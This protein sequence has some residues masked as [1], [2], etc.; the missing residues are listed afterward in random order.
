MGCSRHSGRCETGYNAVALAIDGAVYDLIKAAE[1]TSDSTSPDDH[2]D[3]R[4]TA[5]TVELN[6]SISGNLETQRDIDYFRFELNSAGKI[7]AVTTGDTDT[8]GTLQNDS[9]NVVVTNDDG[10]SSR[11]FLITRVLNPG[12]YYIA[13]SDFL[14]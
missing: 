14:N 2:G 1:S 8:L 6:R 4:G 10:G 12:T 5:T 13:V 9:G 11:N 7:T 3:T